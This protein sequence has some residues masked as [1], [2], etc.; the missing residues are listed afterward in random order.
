MIS[1]RGWNFNCE[2]NN[3]CCVLSHAQLFVTPWSAARQAP[4]SW[5]SPSKNIGVGW[6]FPSPGDLPDAG[7]EPRIPAL[8]ADSLSSEPLEKPEFKNGDH[9]ICNRLEQG[10]PLTLRHLLGIPMTHSSES[11]D[12]R[13][14]EKE[15]CFIINIVF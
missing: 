13:I 11:E 1:W 8:Q 4:L 7:I 3:V 12:T 15:S 6:P 2:F 9:S 5:Y 10:L 14:T